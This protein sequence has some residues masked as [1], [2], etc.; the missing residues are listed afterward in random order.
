MDS[1][2]HNFYTATVASSLASLKSLN[3]TRVKINCVTHPNNKNVKFR[4][5]TFN[6]KLK[7]LDCSKKQRSFNLIDNNAETLL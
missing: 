7:L 3:S 1:R 2:N 4:A 5:R 6:C